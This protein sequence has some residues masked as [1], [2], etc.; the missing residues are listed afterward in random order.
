MML[1]DLHYKTNW[2]Q[3]DRQSSFLSSTTYQT[4]DKTCLCSFDLWFAFGPNSQPF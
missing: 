4:L 2:E 1:L 3:L